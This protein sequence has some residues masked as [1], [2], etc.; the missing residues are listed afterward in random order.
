MAA[1][2]QILPLVV[3][4]ILAVLAKAMPDIVPAG[5]FGLMG[6]GGV[7][8]GQ[9][10]KNKKRFVVMASGGGGW[11]GRPT[12]DGESASVNVCQG[13]VRRAS[14]EE[15]ELKSPVTITKYG[16]RVGSGGAGK[17]RGGN[18]GSMQD[19]KST[20]LNSSH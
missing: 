3:D 1:W 5:H 16:L 6:G 18:A 8:F 12:E 7:F 2:S 17:Y 10:P 19:R 20:R 14:V 4:T 9:N 13:D 15:M 11:G